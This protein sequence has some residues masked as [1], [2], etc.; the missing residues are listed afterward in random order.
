MSYCQEVG[1]RGSLSSSL[2]SSTLHL[3]NDYKASHQTAGGSGRQDSDLTNTADSYDAMSIVSFNSE[4]R[5]AK[6]SFGRCFLKVCL[7]VPRT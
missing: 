7:E 3:Y 2:A 5:V 4:F 1:H 6:S